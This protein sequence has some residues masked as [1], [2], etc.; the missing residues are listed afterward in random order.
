M[1]DA[2]PAPVVPSLDRRKILVGLLFAGAAGLTAAAQPSRRIDYLGET[3]LD[4]LIPK[5]I[6]EWEFETTSGLVVPPEDALSSALYSQLLT[7]VYTDGDQPPIMLLIA[8]SAGQ[9]G[10]LQIHRPEFCYPAGGFQLSSIVPRRIAAG[11]VAFNVNQLTA[12]AP[13]RIEQL[14]YWTRI[15][16][17]MPASWR[18]QR[19]AIA[20]DNLK[21]LI[22]D[23][24]LVRVSTVD[25]DSEASF[26]RLERFVA[27]LVQSL[28]AGDRRVLVTAG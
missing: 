15:G 16:T 22:P 19:L 18:Q 5:K 3:K 26:A 1:A 4:A 9:S 7:R 10:I 13:G 21:G 6:G 2:D 24:V 25:P 11:G 20:M 8:Q 28:P 27:A 14:L 12:T 23:A 17:D